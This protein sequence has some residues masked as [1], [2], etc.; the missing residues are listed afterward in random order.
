VK[1]RYPFN[2]FRL[3]VVGGLPGSGITARRAG[4]L[5][6]RRA[7]SLPAPRPQRTGVAMLQADT[8]PSQCSKTGGAVLCSAL[9]R[10]PP[11]HYLRLDH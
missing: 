1:H 3:V 8:N 9:P 5:F 11:A 7:V 6:L 10:Q 2:G 4:I